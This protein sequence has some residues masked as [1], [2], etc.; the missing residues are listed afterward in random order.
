MRF[1]FMSF[2][3]PGLTFD[4]MVTA[5]AAYG[6]DGIEPR[7]AS[8]HAHGVELTATAQERAAFRR[9]AEEAGVAL[10]CLALSNRYADPATAIQQA[11]DTRRYLDLAA[12]LGISRLRVFGGRIPAEVS[13][14]AAVDGVSAAL[15]SVADDAA[16]RGVAI[17][18]ETHDD[19]CDPRHVAAVMQQVNHPAIAVNWDVLHPLRVTGL[20]FDQ[21]W[22]ILQPWIRH[23]HI[24]DC[25]FSGN[26]FDFVPMGTGQVDHAQ[27]IRVLAQHTYAGF[28]SGEWINWEPY[29]VHLPRELARL[30]KMAG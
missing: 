22:Q 8:Q 5:A 1:A 9:R 7:T 14:Q 18:L 17:C 3:T 19:W 24:H 21:S 2:S 4:Q 28:L 23:V 27:V 11:D 26:T 6:Y 25:T 10:C 20:D 12:D 30:Q 13:R 16:D 15:A 29:A